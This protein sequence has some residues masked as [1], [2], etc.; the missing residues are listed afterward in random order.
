MSK[1]ALILLSLHCHQQRCPVRHASH[2]VSA[3]FIVAQGIRGHPFNVVILNRHVKC[4]QSFL[5]SSN[6]HPLFQKLERWCSPGI[7]MAF[8]CLGDVHGCHGDCVCRLMWACHYKHC[9]F[10][11]CPRWRVVLA[12]GGTLP[13]GPMQAFFLDTCSPSESLPL[14]ELLFRF[15]S[16]SVHFHLEE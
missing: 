13:S 6:P 9:L 10:L 1:P 5:V 2:W 12:L 4:L 14:Y 15:S 3:L 11:L 7:P 8:L 16:V